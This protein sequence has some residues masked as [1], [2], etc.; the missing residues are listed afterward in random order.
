MCLYL[1]LTC[2]VCRRFA[3]FLSHNSGN[4]AVRPGYVSPANIDVIRYYGCQWKESRPR[5]RELH[6]WP[7]FCFIPVCYNR[8]S[9]GSDIPIRLKS[10]NM[11]TQANSSVFSC[12]CIFSRSYSIYLKTTVPLWRINDLSLALFH[13]R[14]KKGPLR[15]FIP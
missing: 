8:T 5:T 9:C 14:N 2:I 7:G 12:S 3:K 10:M 1:S 6:A 11:A 15:A 4:V 13:K